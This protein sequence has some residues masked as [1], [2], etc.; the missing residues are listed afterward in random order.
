MKKIILLV[1]PLALFACTAPRDEVER[2][3]ADQGY[4]EIQVGG[5]DFF[6]C[7]KGDT[8]A[9]KQ[10]S[11]YGASFDAMGRAGLCRGPDKQLWELRLDW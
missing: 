10:I 4:T 1:V 9:F 2:V 11:R 5:H 8:T 7:S 6:G 3:L